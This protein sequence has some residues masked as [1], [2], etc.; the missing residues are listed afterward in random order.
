RHPC[1]LPGL[2][3][4][5]SGREGIWTGRGRSERCR[6]RVVDRPGE[7]AQAPGLRR[8][9][10]VLP[11]AA[12]ARQVTALGHGRLEG[13]PRLG[14]ALRRRGLTRAAPYALAG[15]RGPLTLPGRGGAG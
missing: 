5:D 12:R 4:R 6:G 9:Q 3:A 11:V 7:V 1:W 15:N 14:M 10:L 8:G 2:P 13:R